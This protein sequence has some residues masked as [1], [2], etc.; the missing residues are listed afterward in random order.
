MAVSNT[1]DRHVRHLE[2][3][4]H[5]RVL[6][7][8]QQLQAEINKRNTLPPSSPALLNAQVA[9]ALAG[10]MSPLAAYGAI[11]PLLASFGVVASGAILALALR[12]A[13]VEAEKFPPPTLSGIGP[14]QR[15]TI[16]TNQLRRAAY[17]ISATRRV[18][19]EMSAAHSRGEST[20][21]A[22]DSAIERENVYFLQHVNA[23]SQ[24]ISAANRIDALSGTYGDTLGWYAQHDARVTL[25]CLT[26]NG[27]NFRVSDPPDIGYPGTVHVSCRCY[28]GPPHR[29]AELLASAPLAA[30]NDPLDIVEFAQQ[31]A[32]LYEVPVGLAK[33]RKKV[34]QRSVDYR[35]AESDAKHRC[36]NCVMY[37]ASK[38][39]LVEGFIQPDHVCDRWEAKPQAVELALEQRHVRT[40]RGVYFFKEPIGT[41]ITEAEYQ[42]LLAQRLAAKKAHKAGDPE[43]V[44]AERA[45]RSARRMRGGPD[46]DTGE[47]G[48]GLQDEV[49]SEVDEVNKSADDVLNQV[50]QEVEVEGARNNARTRLTQLKQERPGKT[51]SNVATREDDKRL[52]SREVPSTFV[53]PE[54]GRLLSKS[55]IGD[56]YETLF[57][58]HGAHLLEDTFGGDYQQVSHYSGGARNTPLDFRLDK[59]FGG[60]LKTLSS[61]GKAAARGKLKTSIKKEALDRKH[62][63][64]GKEGLRPLM[65]VQVV[66]QRTG[67]VDVYANEGFASKFVTQMRHLGS[68]DYTPDDF[69]KAN[70]ISGYSRGVTPSASS[71]PTAEGMAA[72]LT[73]DEKYQK[74]LDIRR[75]MQSRYPVGHPERV[76]AERD[77]RQA[78]KVIHGE[79]PRAAPPP[80]HAKPPVRPEWLYERPPAPPP[81]P[82]IR[83]PV[84][85]PLTPK[86]AHQY[87]WTIEP[88]DNGVFQQAAE[89]EI[90]R[91]FAHQAKFVP[92]LLKYRPGGNPVQVDINERPRAGLGS[93]ELGSYSG[94]STSSSIRL[95]PRI[96]PHVV[97]NSTTGRVLDAPFFMQGATPDATL[98]EQ[99]ISHW[100]VP[101]DSKWTLADNVIAHE[102]GHGVNHS[103]F[104]R[105][106][107]DVGIPNDAGFWKKFADVLGVRPPQPGESHNLVTDKWEKTY[108]YTNV[109]RWLKRN[110]S[111]V[112]SALSQYGT[113]GNND[114][115]VKPRE[116]FAELWAEYTLS[117]NPRPLAKFYGDYVSRILDERSQA[118]IRIA[119]SE[120]ITANTYDF[121]GMADRAKF[122]LPFA[123]VTRDGPY[124]EI[125]ALNYDGT[126]S[127][128]P[129]RTF[130][131]DQT[132][133]V[134]NGIRVSA[135][136]I[137]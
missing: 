31:V 65:V 43:R 104:D 52:R 25:E 22:R 106:G 5:L 110:R 76:K 137:P 113:G 46:I 4:R 59:T 88:G 82:R 89:A 103:A 7:Q 105:P 67:H 115:D 18:A 81:P 16:E 102:I 1:P 116:M 96:F 28:P 69:R 57:Q 125:Q 21:A 120:R 118:Q 92:E 27:K 23:D 94:A 66:D 11:A 56:T 78:R 73:E 72:R 60:E 129:T 36:G 79:G 133:G 132:V 131:V 91:Q 9:A 51:A 75:D 85:N 71:T 29:D 55:E 108:Y 50:K 111:M 77:V 101:T 114:S 128:F 20:E 99:K 19:G 54:S 127:G 6:R 48:G 39:D 12:A 97:R 87:T 41:P 134:L 74:L 3:L 117:S 130:S 49:S 17:I 64:I 35:K 24:R 40:E 14:A 135:G 2:H 61:E 47:G 45:V 95:N 68:Y 126:P 98:R 90:N 42:E 33:P 112:V 136:G 121:Y 44:S 80:R 62:L 83:R 53:H 63:A 15:N 122:T 84:L 119:D 30:A 123:R 8:Q 10:A 86:I 34:T 37:H 107:E 70:E 26:A 13:L 124:W 93:A 58:N 38:C 32:N 109:E 100:W